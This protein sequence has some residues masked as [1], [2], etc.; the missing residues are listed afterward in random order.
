[1]KD[2]KNIKKYVRAGYIKKIFS[3]DKSYF[4]FFYSTK[5]CINL[6]R[7]EYKVLELTEASKILI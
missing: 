4:D 6:M 3:L 5:N 2:S 7:K 1:M